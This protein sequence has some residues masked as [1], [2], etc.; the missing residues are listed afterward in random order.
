MNTKGFTLI[1]IIIVLVLLGVLAM[2]AVPKYLNLIETAE[3]QA[4]KGT[5]AEVQ[6]R[7]N[8]TFMDWLLQGIKPELNDKDSDG[9]KIRKGSAVSTLLPMS[10][11]EKIGKKS[12]KYGLADEGTNPQ[13]KADNGVGGDYWRVDGGN[14]SWEFYTFL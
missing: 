6:A 8:Q 14:A 1:E 5:L 7:L 12:Y 13:C 3:I 10:C 11:M 9:N 2:I 4:A